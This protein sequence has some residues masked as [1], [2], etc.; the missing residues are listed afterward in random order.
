[1]GSSN[2]RY[3]KP[4]TSVPE[5]VA[6]LQQR[7]LEVRDPAEAEAL[8][9]RYGYYRLSG[10]T[11][12]YRQGSH[13]SAFLKGTTL[14]QVEM[15][16][17][18][19]EKI[20]SMLLEGISQ[21]EVALRFHIGHRLGRR[22]TFA[23][24]SGAQ[25]EDAFSAWSAGKSEIKPSK[26]QLWLK[27]YTRQENRSQEAFV[28]H[29]RRHYGPHLPVWVATEVMSFG[30]L[31]ELFQAM[32]DNDRKL[33]SARFGVLTRDG[34]GDVGTVSTWL[35]H[36]RHLRNLSAH[37]ARVWNRT[38]DVV[39]GKPNKS[40]V[41]ELA[42]WDAKT[43]R[44]LYGTISVLRF[45]L[46]RVNPSSDWYANILAVITDFVRRSGISAQAMGFPLNWQVQ[47]I[48][49]PDY[50][51]DL[52]LRN[53]VDAIDNVAAVNRREAMGLLT[54]RGN[55][56]DR[57]QW[58]RYL[59]K[60]KALIGHDLGPQ[61]YFPAFQFKDGN[62]L[63]S[64]ANTNESLFGRFEKEGMNPSEA[65]LEVQRWWLTRRPRHGFDSPPIKWIDENPGEVISASKQWSTTD[66]A[67]R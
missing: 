52:H 53:V 37:C 16:Y 34:E 8:L 48:W 57:K 26:H 11:Y 22:D 21:I 63:A 15:L 47:D 58:L 17:H 28:Q 3:K 13:S 36:L 25:F 50:R 29:F 24:R 39:L 54:Q 6:I 38:F 45:L 7:G 32:P 43:V 35:N 4:Y 44:K 20:R 30:T 62:I 10:Y 9:R 18:F 65:A 55:E 51:A 40:A 19:D 60:R 33:V 49:Q 42:H 31:C 14:S 1:M 27:E 41:S 46:A 56:A 23:H 61:V 64:V 2:S 67:I 5:Q 59:R 12:F 66:L